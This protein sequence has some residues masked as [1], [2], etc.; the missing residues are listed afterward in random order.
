MNR[1]YEKYKNEIAPE[2]KKSLN[3]DNVMEVPTIKKIVVNAGVGAIRDNKDFFESF[4][5]EFTNITGQAPSVRKARLSEA[6]FK[7]RQGDIVGIATTLRGQNM[8]AFLDKVTNIVLPRVKDFK[9]LSNKAFDKSGN[10][11]IGITEHVLFP[12]VNPNTTKGSRSMQMTIVTS[13]INKEDSH[14]LLKALGLPFKKGKGN[15]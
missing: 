3:K 1:L 4:K 7:I 8:W 6:G 2:L 12:E 13:A 11:S 5:E 9:G 14:E 15:K 10:Y